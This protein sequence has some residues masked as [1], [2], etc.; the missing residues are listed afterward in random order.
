MVLCCGAFRSRMPPP[1]V[2]ALLALALL[3]A[4]STCNGRSA[5]TDAAA[6]A[7]ET[8]AV[9]RPSPPEAMFDTPASNSA[10]AEGRARIRHLRRTSKLY[11]FRL[12]VGP[13]QP[14]YGDEVAPPSGELTI[15]HRGTGRVVQRIHLAE[16]SEHLS[17]S[18]DDPSIL[19][20]DY[21]FDGHED[22]AARTGD[23]G[24]HGAPTY[25]VFLFAP[26]SRTFAYSR[27][28]SRL[29]E[30]SLGP[31]DVDAS[32][33]RL[34]TG[35]KG[36]CCIH[37]SEEYEIQ[38]GVPRLMARETVDSISDDG[39]VVTLETR[40]GDGGMRREKRPCEP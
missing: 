32:R 1:P 24:P 28:L 23:S 39:C 25:S 36:G 5:Q 9:G 40:R 18:D 7:G 8:D 33:R 15:V 6:S 29:M 14:R 3:G 37:W 22:L 11:D 10:L 27:A 4:L 21:D 13:P 19:V 38:R 26:A 12:D 2:P 34:I 20:E 30:E 16:L 31:I 35:S 17:D